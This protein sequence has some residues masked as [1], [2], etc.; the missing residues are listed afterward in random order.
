MTDY[1]FLMFIERLQSNLAFVQDVAESLCEDLD[2]LELKDLEP[3]DVLEILSAFK[4]I[5]A[6]TE[7]IFK[8]IPVLEEFYKKGAM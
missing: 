5:G 3:K 4:Q 6:Y 7:E 1:E 2:E 8:T